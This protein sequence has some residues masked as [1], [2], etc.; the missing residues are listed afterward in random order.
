MGFKSK[1]QNLFLG[2]SDD[3]DEL[4]YENDATINKGRGASQQEYEEYYEESTPS[5]TQKEDSVRQSN[6]APLHA[7]KKTKSQVILSE[8]RV[9]NEA[10]EIG[11]HLRQN[12]AV[13]VNMQRMSKDQSRQMI[14]FLSGVVFALD[15]TITTISQNTLLCVPNNV[16]LAGSISNLLGEDDIN[17]KGW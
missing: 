13:I 4:E 5:V 16:E 15:G 17:H 10:Q 12:R 3:L 11:E 7:T 14:N 1:M 8:P 6:I 9:F 2:N